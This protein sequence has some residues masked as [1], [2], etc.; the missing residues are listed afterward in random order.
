MIFTS[1]DQKLMLPGTT[2]N[3]QQSLWYF[4][5]IVELLGNFSLIARKN[6]ILVH[7]ARQRRIFFLPLSQPET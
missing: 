3:L 6:N 4:F 7:K 5:Q 2:I 1:V